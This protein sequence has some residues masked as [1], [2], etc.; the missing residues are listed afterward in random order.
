MVVQCCII[1]PP[2]GY[3]STTQD[4]FYAARESY[5]IGFPFTHKNDDFGA[6]SVTDGASYIYR[7]GFAQCEFLFRPWRLKKVGSLSYYDDDGSEKKKTKKTNLRAFKQYR[8]YLEPLNSSNVGD[9][10]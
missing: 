6:I 4:I 5:R 9:F 8:V 10:S 1:Q 7:I 2:S 3:V